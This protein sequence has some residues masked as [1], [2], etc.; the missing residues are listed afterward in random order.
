MEARSQQIIS[1]LTT[2]IKSKFQD[3]NA[4]LQTLSQLMQQYEGVSMDLIQ[5]KMKYVEIVRQ[6]SDSH[7]FRPTLSTFPGVAPNTPTYPLDKMQ[8]DSKQLA[9][10]GNVINDL[11]NQKQLIYNQVR[12]TLEAI[13]VTTTS[14][15]NTVDQISVFLSQM[16]DDSSLNGLYGSPTLKNLVI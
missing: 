3:Q 13:V 7:D 1:S 10:M 4:Y 9:E 5:M 14:A 15:S 2:D 12:K 16:I 11:E 8:A 6:Y